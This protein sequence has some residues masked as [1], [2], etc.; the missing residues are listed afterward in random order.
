MSF[1]LLPVEQPVKARVEHTSEIL[2]ISVE[3]A[4]QVWLIFSLQIVSFG[5]LV[6]LNHI[7]EFLLFD[8]LVLSPFN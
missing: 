3:K 2:I 5:L 1:K 6:C 7:I 4:N 8:S